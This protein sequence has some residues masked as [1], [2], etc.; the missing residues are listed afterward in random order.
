MA[1]EAVARDG[2][3]LKRRVDAAVRTLMEGF[4]ANVEASKVSTEDDRHVN[5]YMQRC[6]TAAREP[7]I[8]DGSDLLK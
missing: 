3:Q 5:G 2:R 4:I 1:V 8:G 6:Y 7:I